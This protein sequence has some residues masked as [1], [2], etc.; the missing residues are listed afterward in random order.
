MDEAEPDADE[1]FKEIE[2]EIKRNRQ[3]ALR[4]DIE[5]LDGKKQQRNDLMSCLGSNQPK[6]DLDAT[7]S[8]VC[9]FDFDFKIFKST[10]FSYFLFQV[11][12]DRGRAHIE[13]QE[14]EVMKRVYELRKNIALENRKKT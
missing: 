13:T 9:K 5:E 10:W 7:D 11:S 4:P 12:L 3:D 6:K 1:L 8:T 2:V 14:R